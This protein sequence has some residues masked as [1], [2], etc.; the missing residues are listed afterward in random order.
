MYVPGNLSNKDIKNI[1]SSDILRLIQMLQR[2]EQHNGT[3]L[4]IPFKRIE[5]FFQAF[6]NKE[7]SEIDISKTHLLDF[8]KKLKELATASEPDKTDKQAD[9]IINILISFIEYFYFF[10]TKEYAPYN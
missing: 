9:L 5:E 6:L 1:I 8:L 10:L 4:A 3:N 2:A 7:E